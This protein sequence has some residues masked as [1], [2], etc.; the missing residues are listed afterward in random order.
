MD[1][2]GTLQSIS[3]NPVLVGVLGGGVGSIAFGGVMYALRNY[4]TRVWNAGLTLASTHFTVTTRYRQFENVGRLLNECAFP[5]L[6]RNFMPGRFYDQGPGVRRVRN[7]VITSSRKR[8]S[9]APGYGSHWGSYKGKLISYDRRMLESKGESIEE[10]IDVRFYTRDRRV[11]EDFLLECDEVDNT[12]TVHMHVSNGPHF[13]G[14]QEKPKRSLDTVFMNESTKRA[15]VERIEWF[16]ANEEWY[17]ERGIPYKFC[18]ILHGPAGTGKTS[19]IHALASEFGLTINY[20]SSLM[21]VSELLADC[22]DKDLIVI[23]DVDA[24]SANL[25]RDNET[26]TRMRLNE[27]SELESAPSEPKKG[28]AGIILHKMLNAIDGFCTPHGLKIIMTTNHPER[29][30]PALVRPGR[31][32]MMIEVGA[33]EQDEMVAMFKRFYGEEAG[34]L[35][36]GTRLRPRRGA[37]L[38][39]IFIKN[40]PKVAAAALIGYAEAAE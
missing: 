17:L 1:I 13:G 27:R 35:L 36:E 19:L 6:Q 34:T 10:Q 4:P 16:M 3:T 38:Q 30:D 39:E 18:A 14:L 24:L 22:S 29:L 31:T 40:G 9:L 33:L 32:D 15:V 2:A 28:D 37:E 26:V 20:I 11:I 23:E 7:K 12:D 5:R 25:N 21:N 8:V